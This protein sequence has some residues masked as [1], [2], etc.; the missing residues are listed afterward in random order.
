VTRARPCRRKAH[1]WNPAIQTK[2]RTPK[3]SCGGIGG[4][5]SDFGLRCVFR[6][7]IYRHL[8]FLALLAVA[9]S[10]RDFGNGI[11]HGDCSMGGQCSNLAASFLHGRLDCLPRMATQRRSE[12]RGLTVPSG[13]KCVCVKCI[14]PTKAVSRFAPHRTPRRL[15]RVL[16]IKGKVD[17]LCARE[18]PG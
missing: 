4:V 3:G 1:P 13:R 9:A 2:P 18:N 17:P 12:G 10:I 14:Y 15:R 6:L 8:P 11:S 7:P 16:F 5:D